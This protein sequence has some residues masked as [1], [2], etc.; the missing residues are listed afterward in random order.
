MQPKMQDQL[1]TRARNLLSSGLNS[2]F[3]LLQQV[4]NNISKNEDSDGELY[5]ASTPQVPENEAYIMKGM[6]GVL[7]FPTTSMKDGQRKMLH[8]NIA[9]A[10]WITY[11]NTGKRVHLCS[12]IISLTK[13]S[14]NQI[15]LEM[16]GNRSKKIS[17]DKEGLADK[18]YTYMQFINEQGRAIAKAFN[19][20]DYTKTGRISRTDLEKA[21]V[22]ADL[23]VDEDTITKM[24]KFGATGYEFVDYYNFFHLFMHSF[25]SSLRE[26]LQEWLGQTAAGDDDSTGPFSSQRLTSMIRLIPGE[27]ITFMPPERVHW[28]VAGG[29]P[30]SSPAQHATNALTFPGRLCA[31]N[32]R[33]I[34]LSARRPAA[35]A[36]QLVHSR[37]SVPATF[38]AVSIPLGQI[39]KLMAGPPSHSLYLF[40]KDYR[41][42]RV[43]LAGAENNKGAAEA[44]LQILSDLAFPGSR[45]PP[46]L[47]ALSSRLSIRLNSSS[48]LNSPL[49]PGVE[50]GS[51]KGGDRGIS[52]KGYSEQQQRP[53]EAGAASAADLPLTRSS[54]G[55]AEKDAGPQPTLFAFIH[56]SASDDLLQDD[57][58]QS[59]SSAAVNAVT[60]GDLGL[61]DCFSSSSPVATSHSIAFSNINSNKQTAAV[62]DAEGWSHADLIREYNR[63]GIID[64]RSRWRIFDNGDY[65]MT[66]TYPAVIVVPR[67]M[68]NAQ[69]RQAAAF[70]S[71]GRL[72]VVTYR[73]AGTEAVLTR[74]AQPLVGLA[75]KT[76]AEDTMLLDLYRLQGHS[77][78]AEGD[79]K[80]LYILDAR[81]V[82]A[83]TLNKAAGKGTEDITQYQNTEL[84]F[85]NV[86]NIHVMRSSGNALAESLRLSFH[87]HAGAQAAMEQS[88]TTTVD[89]SGWLRHLR[90][91]LSASV[92][93]AEK[94]HCDGC[95]VLVHCS[96][97]WDRTA[98][99][100]SLTQILLDPYFRT[101]EGMATLIEKDWCAFGHKF[102]ERLGHG[103]D[104]YVE[105]DE[106]CPVFLQ[107]LDCL[108][109]IIRQLPRCF[110]FDERLL[111]FLADM[112]T[113]SLFGTFLGNNDRQRR[114]ELNCLSTTRSIWAYIKKRSSRFV[115]G[116]YEV[117]SAPIWPALA[118]HRLVLWERYWL[119]WDP[120]AHPTPLSGRM[121][122]VD[123]WGDSP[124]DDEVSTENVVETTLTNTILPSEFI[125]GSSPTH[126]GSLLSKRLSKR[127]SSRSHLAGEEKHEG[128]SGGGEEESS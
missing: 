100:C 22:K 79:F 128:G 64:A 95:S 111:I 32:Y 67:N 92:F 47:A 83:A 56:G 51:E 25:V 125:N 94:M 3:S 7:V 63:Q 13:V 75:Q 36:Q 108:F 73:H 68:D 43:T 52:E 104:S 106:R 81:S 57:I 15:N 33:V 37:Y 66:R 35:A 98:Q 41:V 48:S 1:K 59:S 117:F 71:Q 120:T 28:S 27:V 34:F 72:P 99:I 96:D 87:P 54:V 101:I 127:L 69:I 38:A 26:C 121:M 93:A 10:H 42:I 77:T 16:K 107:F 61:D 123:D 65:D 19:Q 4:T 90:L 85:C 78:N 103:R 124:A 39:F 91:L 29:T 18:F 116:D 113:S 88:V 23:R 112:S 102:E 21:L 5:D 60:E 55:A 20:I 118:P 46:S 24:L 80:R 6:R 76:S 82:L 8:I 11:H 86:E 14:E 31:T 17:F 40:G 84:C 50:R 53:S 89:D 49:P 110:E 44:F 62:N 114:E 30:S 119:R 105:P 45:P 122:W 2:G 126:N 109:Q 58:G 70:R 74:S 9:K 97:G 115:R 12:D